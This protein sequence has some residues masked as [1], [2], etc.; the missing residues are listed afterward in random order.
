MAIA[1][2]APYHRI[3]RVAL[4]LLLAAFAGCGDNESPEISAPVTTWDDLADCSTQ[5]E[6]TKTEYKK[7]RDFDRKRGD[8]DTAIA[9]YT[10]AIRLDPDYTGAY[11]SRGNAYQDKD[12]FDKAAS[13]SGMAKA[14]QNI[15]N[16]VAPDTKKQTVY[17]TKTGTKYHRGHCRYLSKSKIPMCLR[18]A[19]K[20]R[21]PC[22]VCR[23]PK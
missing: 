22:S 15:S 1:A 9:C 23:P 7:S 6:Q 19:K 20:F 21:E 13:L 11:I 3:Y 5:D 4:V 2:M 16:T 10:E 8:M 14:P 12:D 18:N 17:I